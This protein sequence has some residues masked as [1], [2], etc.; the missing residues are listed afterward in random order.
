M[1]IHVYQ[2]IENRKV[3]YG[4]M[5]TDIRELHVNENI[6][7]TTY[8]ICHSHKLNQEI[9]NEMVSRGIAKPFGSNRVHRPYRWHPALASQIGIA[10][11]RGWEWD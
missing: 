11:F 10:A 5:S 2:Y 4:R 3:L 8:A 1:V 9:I 6:I 7:Y